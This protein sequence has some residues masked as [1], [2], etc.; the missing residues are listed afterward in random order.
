MPSN[1]SETGARSFVHRTIPDDPKNRHPED[2]YRTPPVA[3]QRLLAVE[4]FPGTVWEPACGDGLMAE[5]LK[6]VRTRVFSTDL[7]DRGYGRS[8]VDFLT[9]PRP[10]FKFDHIVT[11]PPFTL[12]REFV[13]RALFYRPKTVAMIARLSW[14]EGKTRKSFF[15]NS[16]LAKVWVFSGRVN[17]ARSGYEFRDGGEGG[18][19]A[20]AWYVWKRD[21]VG[22]P[23]LGWI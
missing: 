4:K 10:R 2:F 13:E 1:H 19:I 23:T 5:E 20:Y 21:H 6:K 11:N 7:H 22:P 15:E 17:I 9:S 12:V 16:P 18:M 3:T 8:G 14:L